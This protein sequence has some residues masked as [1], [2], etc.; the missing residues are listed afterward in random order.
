[1]ALDTIGL[2]IFVVGIALIIA[3]AFT[4]GTFIMVP[5]I[6]LTLVGVVLMAFPSL[7]TSI[8]APIIFLLIFAVAFV[9]V[10]YLY[11]NMAQP[12]RPTTMSSDALIGRIAYVTRDVIPG[13]I[14]GKVKIEQEIWSA[15]AD[16]VIPEGQK[17]E[18]IRVEGVKVIVRPFFK[19]E[20]STWEAAEDI[21]EVDG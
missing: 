18:V 8:W 10:F 9:P 2:V 5:G 21:L 7:T 11:K 16:Q 17:V 14:R 6:A 4:P 3:E 1:M 12:E 20:T 19:K 13:N 15:T